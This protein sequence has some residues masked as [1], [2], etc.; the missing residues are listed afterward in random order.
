MKWLVQTNLFSDP[1]FHKLSEALTRLNCDVTYLNVIPFSHE[2]DPK[3]EA[4]NPITVM[5]STSLV[6][7]AIKEGW[8][9]GVFFNEHFNFQ[10]WLE[11]YGNEMLNASAQLVRWEDL[12]VVDVSFVRPLD[13]LKAFNG[14]VVYPDEF[15][16]WRDRV[17]QYSN[18]GL[19]SDSLIVV[20]EPLAIAREY[21]FFVIDNEVVTGSMYKLNGRL[22][23]NA[24]VEDDVYDYVRRIISIWQPDRAFVLDIAMLPTGEL[25]VIEIN[26]LNSAGFYHCDVQK[27]VAKL[28]ALSI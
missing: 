1:N 5:G 18:T 4:V 11:N 7:I 21:R 3:P 8:K 16:E 28:D 23:Q 9:P 12:E 19:T 14:G 24:I 26:N 15:S 25:K 2:L 22:F 6:K 10:S 17:S 13:D 20:S 27:I